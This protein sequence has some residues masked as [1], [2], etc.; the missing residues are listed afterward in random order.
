MKVDI[1]VLSFILWKNIPL[2]TM[3]HVNGRSMIDA[4]SRAK[5][6]CILSLLRVL[7][8]K[9]SE[10]NVELYEMPLTVEVILWIFSFILLIR[11]GKSNV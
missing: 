9:K 2:F 1:S 10:I 4:L 5:S 8:F 11:L 7:F 6:L 3:M